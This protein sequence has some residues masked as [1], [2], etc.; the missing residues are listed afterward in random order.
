MRALECVTQ[1]K[2]LQAHHGVGCAFLIQPVIV[3]MELFEQLQQS[4]LPPVDV[5]HVLFGVDVLTLVATL[6]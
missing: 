3:S 4:L 1:V 2:A 5:G 6:I